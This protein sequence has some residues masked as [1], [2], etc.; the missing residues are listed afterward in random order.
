M[1]SKMF[2]IGLHKTLLGKNG[3]LLRN[4]H[5]F[6]HDSLFVAISVEAACGNTSNLEKE[7]VTICKI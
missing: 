2:F 7:E 4:Q 5:L 1:P 3:I 6:E